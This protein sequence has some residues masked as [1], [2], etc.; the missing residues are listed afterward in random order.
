MK[1]KYSKDRTLRQRYNKKELQSFFFKFLVVRLKNFPFLTKL[2][3]SNI[4]R[5]FFLSARLKKRNSKTQL[6]NR[7]I[8]SNRSRG[9]VKSYSISRLKFLELARFGIIPGYKKAVW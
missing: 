8:L 9:I 5:I 7:C 4:K 6:Y 3:S 2:S 1:I